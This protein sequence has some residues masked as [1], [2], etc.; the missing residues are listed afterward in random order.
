MQPLLVIAVLLQ[1]LV[2]S[3]AQSGGGGEDDDDA[4]PRGC[5][6]P[7]GLNTTAE[8][9]WETNLTAEELRARCYSVCL[10]EQVCI[11]Y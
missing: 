3:E 4:P 10:S 1:L 11:L 5:V 9:S 7:K 6:V 2:V 8:L